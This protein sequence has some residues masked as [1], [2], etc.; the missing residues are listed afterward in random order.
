MRIRVP[1]VVL[2]LIV[3]AG[4]LASGCGISERYRERDKENQAKPEDGKKEQAD[5]DSPN[6]AQDGT[7]RPASMPGRRP[8]S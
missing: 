3:L 1:H 8:A 7:F 2:T 5:E 4:S 6:H